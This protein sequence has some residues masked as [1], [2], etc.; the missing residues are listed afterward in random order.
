MKVQTIE[1][2]C[3]L[4]NGNKILG[5]FPSMIDSEIVFNGKNNVLFCESGKFGVKLIKSCLKFNA[6]N[7]VIF[8]SQNKH[9]Y[10]QLNVSV[11]N[12]NVFYIGKI[13]I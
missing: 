6:D 1:D 9:N 5:T 2:V 3:F 11:Y 12:D 4:E 10:E 8:L 7:S 13:I